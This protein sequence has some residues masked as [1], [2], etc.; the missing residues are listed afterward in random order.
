MSKAEFSWIKDLISTDEKALGVYLAVL[1]LR[2]LR[3]G[4]IEYSAFKFILKTLIDIMELYLR[5]K[6]IDR[7]FGAKA[8]NLTET[9]DAYVAFSIN[10]LCM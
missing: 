10:S 1:N 9:F 5:V 7:V 6:D 2:F 3:A 4:D 8:F